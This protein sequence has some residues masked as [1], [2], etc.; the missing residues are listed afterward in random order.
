MSSQHTNRGN[1]SNKNAKNNTLEVEIK[2]D[3]T[4]HTHS[5]IEQ[6]CTVQLNQ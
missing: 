1:D 2:F 6:N 5:R 3:I 4:Q